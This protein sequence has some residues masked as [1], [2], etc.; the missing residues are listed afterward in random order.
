MRHYP[1][2]NGDELGDAEL[3]QA[4]I[5]LGREMTYPPTPD[6]SAP[7]REGIESGGQHSSQSLQPGRRWRN[8]ARSTSILV[9]TLD[10]ISGKQ[11]KGEME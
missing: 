11:A 8:G 2:N 6:L 1:Q 4:L 9:G 5:D 3:E 10:T 7:V